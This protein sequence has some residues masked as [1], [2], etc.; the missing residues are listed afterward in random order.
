ME[1]G[2]FHD[3]RGELKPAV[4]DYLAAIKANG[5]EP[6]AY[7]RLGDLLLE[8]A[9]DPKNAVV[10]FSD[11]LKRQPKLVH[12]YIARG[13]AY[14]AMDQLELAVTDLNEAVSLN[15][16]VASSYDYRGDI[17]LARREYDAALRDY[18]TALKLDNK[19][20]VFHFDLANALS[21]KGDIRG[22]IRSFD[23]AISLQPKFTRAYLHRAVS[24]YKLN[25]MAKSRA[26][27]QMAAEIDPKFK[28]LEVKQRN[29]NYL[30]VTNASKE[31]LQVY[32]HYYTPS[33]GGNFRWYP[34]D[35]ATN[36]GI[37][38]RLEPGESSYI[39]HKAFGDMRVKGAKFRIWA[40]GLN[41]GGVDQTYKDKDLV[42]AS[43]DGYVDIDYKTFD[44][45]FR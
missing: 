11:A 17:F 18:S 16:N 20:P 22:A 23:A 4:D 34:D 35:P 29:V 37:N 45:T 30:R 44:Y 41:S 1:R 12:A 38:L 8:K 21:S 40:K 32:I 24:H 3:I 19:N 5:N 6:G 26:D 31:P 13:R 43:A 42:A 39:I 27:M 14:L 25:D 33:V 2:L 10:Y 7:S 28:N 36:E 9:N 15:P